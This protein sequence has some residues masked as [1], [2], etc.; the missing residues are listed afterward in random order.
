MVETKMKSA[1]ENV[2]G[3]LA[4]S[5]WRTQKSALQFSHDVIKGE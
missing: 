1:S 2:R 4:N 3:G 5:P